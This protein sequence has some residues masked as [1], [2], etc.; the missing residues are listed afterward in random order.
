MPLTAVG[1]PQAELAARQSRCGIVSNNGPEMHAR[2]TPET[3][4]PSVGVSHRKFLGFNA[5]MFAVPMLCTALAANL[6]YFLQRLTRAAAVLRGM[7]SAVLSNDEGAGL[8]VLVD[9][10]FEVMR[11]PVPSAQSPQRLP[12]ACAVTIGGE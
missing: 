4:A 7:W 8:A 11:G 12:C 5:D 3:H 2:W 1:C 6:P 9:V 10:H